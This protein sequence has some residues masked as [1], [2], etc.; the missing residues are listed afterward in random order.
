MWDDQPMP[1]QD[2][3]APPGSEKDRDATSAAATD[4]REGTGAESAEH[5]PRLAVFSRYGVASTVL[6]VISVVAL[7]LGGLIWKS[8]RDDAAERAYLTRVMQ[9]AADWT[10]VLINMNSTNIDA[11][12]Q[13]LHDATVGDL[14]TEFDAAIAPYRQVVQKLQAQSRGQVES[15]AIETVR[16]DL[17][18]RPGAPR[19]VVTTK[20]P[21]MATRTD[22]VMVVAT[23]IAENVGGK[24]QTVHWSLRLEM[25]DV[26]EKILV[27]GLESIR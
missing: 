4:S 2:K 15:A 22:S 8:H 25:S 10:G 13:R 23:S 3:V 5:G 24:P 21:A 6:A 18:A 19:D 9:A 26:N 7:V 17:G 1:D 11:S 16:H 20:L 12:L 14:N 27:S